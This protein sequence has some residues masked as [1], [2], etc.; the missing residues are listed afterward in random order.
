VVHVGEGPVDEGKN[1][2]SREL[3]MID[4]EGHPKA[5]AFHLT[6]KKYVASPCAQPRSSR[7]SLQRLSALADTVAQR[8][9][10]QG[11]Y[12]TRS[13]SVGGLPGFGRSGEKELKKVVVGDFRAR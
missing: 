12:R 8:A 3:E 13:V 5:P 2:V 11:K 10:E 1:W 4:P 9:A 7:S 6:T